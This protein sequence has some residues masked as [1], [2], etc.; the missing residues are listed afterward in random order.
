MFIDP[1]APWNPE[2]PAPPPE[3]PPPLPAQPQILR[4]S[5]TRPAGPP[6]RRRKRGKK[7]TRAAIKIGALNIRG[8][9]DLNSSGENNKWL[10]MNRVMNEHKLGITIICEA[11]LED[12]RARSIDRVFARQMAVRFSRN[13]RTSNADGIAFILNKSLVDTSSIVTKEIIPGRAF[14]LETKQHNS[15]PLSVLGD[16]ILTDFICREG[17]SL[18]NNLEAVSENDAVNRN[19][20]HNAQMLWKEFKDRIYEKGRE[21][22]KVS[23]SKIKNEIAELEADLETILDN[24]QKRFRDTGKNAR[25]RHKLEAEVISE[26]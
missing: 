7:T 11:H 23:V 2:P 8:T 5:M 14:V 15:A 1:F 9:G 16:K 21:R 22:A 6:G 18:V 13:A 17:I 20:N 24:D 4:P 3:P 12:A 26:Y 10:Q 19:P 25:I